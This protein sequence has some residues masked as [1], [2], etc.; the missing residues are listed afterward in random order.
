MEEYGPNGKVAW[1]YRHFPLI[2]LHPKAPQEAAATECAAEIG[3]ELKFWEYTDRLFEITPSNNRLDLTL[4]PQIAEDVGLDR[5][6]FITC[7][8]SGRTLA[9]VEEDL[10][11]ALGSGGTGTPHTIL[12]SKDGKNALPL[13]GAQSFDTVK[14]QIEQLLNS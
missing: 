8:E 2:S 12:I 3:G 14:A 13:R 9:K 11:D 6:E 5:E 7:L 10:K 4:L 1:V